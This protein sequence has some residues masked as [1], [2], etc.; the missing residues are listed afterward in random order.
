M[1]TRMMSVAMMLAAGLCLAQERNW[2]A[3]LARVE[4]KGEAWEQAYADAAKRLYQ[5]Q[6]DL[7]LRA[8]LEEKLQAVGGEVL[9][10][11]K[12]RVAFGK[13]PLK[14]LLAHYQAKKALETPA[15][16]VKAARSAADFPGGVPADARRVTARL[17]L[18][19]L[20]P[21]WQSTGL[22]AAPGETVTVSVSGLPEGAALTGQIGCHADTLGPQIKS[23]ND[24]I[25]D[26]RSLRRWPVA[27]RRFELKNGDNTMAYALGGLVYFTVSKA[28]EDARQPVCVGVK[29]CVE[30]PFFRAGTDT[31][32]AWETVLSK[33]PAPWAEID[34]GC[35]I[36]TMPAGVIRENRDL[37]EVCAWWQKASALIYRMAGR[38]PRARVERVVDDTQISAGGGHSGYPVMQMGWSKGMTNLAALKKSGHWGTLHEL[39]HNLGQ[40]ANR[41]FS[42]PGNGEVVC[43][44]YGCY[45]MNTLNGTPLREIR[46]E[47]WRGVEKKMRAGE[48]KMWEAGGHFERLCFYLILAEKFGWDIFIEA[49]NDQTEAPGKGPCDRMCGLFSKAAKADLA[50]YFMQWGFEPSEESRTFTA[51]WPAVPVLPWPVGE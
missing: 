47:G 9:V 40:G 33:R 38:S 39:G 37:P 23:E 25:V 48:K 7:K 16:E 28:P 34:A 26:G 17:E 41:A 29:G 19:P 5:R 4:T 49:V 46:P 10:S 22:Y 18:K 45:V 3:E 1:K 15:G 35:L 42:L 27:V 30:A 51:Q 36:M 31:A 2:P 44:V 11:P 6:P 13:E 8:A 20:L 32:E 21:G 43:N 50:P 24:Q 14:L 12:S